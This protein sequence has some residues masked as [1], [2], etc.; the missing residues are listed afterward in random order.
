VNDFE[1]FNYVISA[2]ITPLFLVAGTFFPLT[3]LPE[4]AQ[5][6]AN[7]NPLYHL[8]EL[9]RHA[10]FGLQPGDDLIHLGVLL[11]FALV[12]W[13]LAVWRMSRRLIG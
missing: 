7:L 5:T 6:L 3:E 13:R 2:G 4:W 11:L 8:V 10:V 1:N 9:V 12:A